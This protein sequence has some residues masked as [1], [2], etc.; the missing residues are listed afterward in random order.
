MNR[1][2]LYARDPEAPVADQDALHAVLV[3]A[4]FIGREIIV[5]GA[6]RFEPGKRFEE[7]LV[8]NGPRRVQH[9][10]EISEELT[11]ID[12]L[13]G[14]NVLSPSCP[15]GFTAEN[16]RTLL[17]DWSSDREAYRWS[18]P[19]CAVERRLWE[20]DWK[21]SAAFGRCTVNVLDVDLGEAVPRTALLETLASSHHSAWDY[22]YRSDSLP[23]E[24]AES[25]D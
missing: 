20:L 12:F 21:H 14:E 23:R 17:A 25:L 6:R 24:L 5:T 19:S 9:K 15:C 2:V 11:E 10:I 13:G 4:G 7:L 16:W 1:L 22:F 18:C 3:A 8:L